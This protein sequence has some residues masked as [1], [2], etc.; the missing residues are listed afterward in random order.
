MNGFQEI[1][2]IADWKYTFDDGESKQLKGRN[3]AK[4]IN[5]F[6]SI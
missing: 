1:V 3:T 2:S 6:D 4:V 5:V